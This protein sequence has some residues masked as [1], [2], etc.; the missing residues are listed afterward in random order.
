MTFLLVACFVSV[1]WP[2]LVFALLATPTTQLLLKAPELLA[3]PGVPGCF[4]SVPFEALVPPQ[5]YVVVRSSSLKVGQ[6][7]IQTLPPRFVFTGG[8]WTKSF[9]SS[10]F[11]F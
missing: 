10:F 6:S 7:W 1:S 8:L 9:T 4:T 2:L 3:I 5:C 11:F